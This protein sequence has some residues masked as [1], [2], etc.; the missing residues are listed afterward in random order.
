M[1]TGIWDWWV[2]TIKQY[3]RTAS[4]LSHIYKKKLFFSLETVWCESSLDTFSIIFG[5]QFQMFCSPYLKLCL[6]NFILKLCYW[7][8]HKSVL[9]WH[10]PY[11]NDLLL[12]FTCVWYVDVVHGISFPLIVSSSLIDLFIVFSFISFWPC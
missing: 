4:F 8:P 6:H 7:Q 9:F 1:K 5:G 11:H 2:H 3:S 10:D 12:I